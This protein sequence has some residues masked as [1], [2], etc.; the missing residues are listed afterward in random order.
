MDCQRE[1]FLPSHAGLYIHLPFCLKKCHY[2]DFY[3]IEDLSLRGSFVTALLE[4]IKLRSD[5]SLTVDTIYLGGGTPSLLHCSDIEKIM[6]EVAENFNIMADTQ[7]TMEVNPGAIT[8]ISRRAV[9]STKKDW[10]TDGISSSHYLSTIHGLGINRLSIGIQSFQDEKLSFLTRV[11]S[12][13]DARQAIVS[14]RGAGF[15]DIGM[16]LMYGVPKESERVWL[17][18]LEAALQYSPEHLS[19]YMLSYEPDTPMFAA[20]RRREIKPLKEESCS[21]LFRLTSNH[22]VSNGF[23]HY[24]ISNFAS[25]AHH[26]SRHNKKYW[27]MVPYLGFG[28]SAHSY[29]G[30]WKRSWN[31]KNVAKYISMLEQKELPVMEKEELTHEQRLMEMIM[32]GLRREKGID[33]NS[34][35]TFSGGQFDTMFGNVLEDIDKRGWGSIHNW[36]DG[37]EQSQSRQKKEKQESCEIL[38]GRRF[39]L[40][41]EGWLFLDTITMWFVEAIDI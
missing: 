6:V 26:Q 37:E 17:N 1:I 24:E 21:D 25:T 11:H 20:Y 16:D 14:A 28:P 36:K 41:L 33:I 2:C 40:T 19:C 10:L 27:D 15:H 31:I 38:N 5:L 23:S 34:F 8:D 39:I 35:E 30:A 32:V 29:D 13:D 22:L 3:S 12:A 4:E 7:I 18:D 9:S